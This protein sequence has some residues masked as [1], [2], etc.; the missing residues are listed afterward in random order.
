[1]L[2]ALQVMLKARLKESKAGEQAEVAN[3]CGGHNP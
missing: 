1:M 3:P 2:G